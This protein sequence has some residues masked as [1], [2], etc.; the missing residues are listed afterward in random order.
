MA[1]SAGPGIRPV[2]ADFLDHDPGDLAHALAFDGDH[3]VGEF[4]D[5]PALCS[6]VNTS[7][8]SLT[9]MSGIFSP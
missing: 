2:T 5:D 7:S 9:L 6:G 1:T 4:L 3:R 8:M